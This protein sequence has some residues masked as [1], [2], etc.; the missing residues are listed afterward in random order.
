MILF[1]AIYS[2][3][4]IIMII[5]LEWFFK[6]LPLIYNLLLLQC[7]TMLLFLILGCINVSNR[8]ICVYI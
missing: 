4:S 5:M 2:I 3:A 8:K 6:R 1:D 7:D